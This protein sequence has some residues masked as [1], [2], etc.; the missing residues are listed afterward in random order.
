MKN[1]DTQLLA[2]AYDQITSPTPPDI[3]PKEMKDQATLVP[4]PVHPEM[5]PE[6]QRKD[7][8][9]MNFSM[10]AHECLIG[11]EHINKKYPDENGVIT[12][13]V[14]KDLRRI[15]DILWKYIE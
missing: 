5:T 9:R 15:Y 4:K 8:A 7:E 14:K 13:E 1:K 3:F 12:N 2:E 10:M 11:I 6:E